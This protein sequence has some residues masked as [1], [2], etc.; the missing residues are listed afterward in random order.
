VGEGPALFLNQGDFMINAVS[1]DEF[2][3]SCCGPLAGLG[4]MGGREVFVLSAQDR[5]A[6][7]F[8]KKVRAY[9]DAMNT[10]KTFMS[11][12][13]RQCGIDEIVF[14][15]AYKDAVGNEYT[16]EVKIVGGKD[17]SEN[18]VDGNNEESRDCDDRHDSR[19]HDYE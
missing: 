1:D 13:M 14:K 19:D 11:G 8:V 7:D 6:K 15:G 5:R 17:N 10:P 16:A 4:K 18:R 2:G 3:L 9:S 12:C